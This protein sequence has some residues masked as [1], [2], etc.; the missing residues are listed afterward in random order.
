[1]FVGGSHRSLFIS[2]YFTFDLK[3]IIA[4]DQFRHLYRATY[5]RDYNNFYF[6]HFPDSFQ[7]LIQYP[8][9]VTAQS[10]KLVSRCRRSIV[11]STITYSTR[12]MLM[13]VN[14]DDVC[15]CIREYVY[16]RILVNVYY[17]NV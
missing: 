4:F 2:C 11:H 16:V 3:L 1:M 12:A 5:P 8:D 7:V 14:N 10:A 17:N 6:A 13:R 15:V 9:V